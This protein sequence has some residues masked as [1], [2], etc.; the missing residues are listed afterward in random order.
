MGDGDDGA[1][2]V[3]EEP[4][5]PGHGLGV[6][7][8][9]RLVQQQQVGLT[10]QEPAER[11]APALPAR[12]RGHILIS[13]WKAQ[14]VH[15][16]IDG[17]VEVPEPLRLDLVL[18]LLEVVAQRLHLRG[19]QL[20]AELRREVVEP[21]EHGL[22]CRDA[23]FH[24][25]A[26]VLRRV[27]LRLLR[28]EPDAVT[29]GQAGVAQIFGVHAGHDPEEGA[30]AGAIRAEHADLGAR[31]EGQVDPFQDLALAPGGDLLEIAH[32]EDELGR[33]VGPTTVID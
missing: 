16:E 30:L 21:L 19:A 5:E 32:G 33:H 14:R 27:E 28:E 7:V 17:R 15:R 18:G 13:G 8:V 12:Q 9:R 6:Q 10:K 2:V 22:L 3:L 26:D 11:D 31:V 24:V 23:L 20:F 25:P 1:R 4:L 29:I